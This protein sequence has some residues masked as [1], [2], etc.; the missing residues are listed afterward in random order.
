V[1]L[2]PPERLFYPFLVIG[3]C[4]SN[5]ADCQSLNSFKGFSLVS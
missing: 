3:L 2:S 1:V 5:E 4:C